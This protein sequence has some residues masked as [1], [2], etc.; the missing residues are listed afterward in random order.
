MKR[1]ILSVFTLFSLLGATAQVEVEMGAGYANQVFYSLENGVVASSPVNNWDLAF[2]TSGQGSVIRTNEGYGAELSLYNGPLADFTTLDTS[3]FEGWQTLHNSDASWSAGAF[4]EYL[5]DDFDLGWGMYSMVTHTVSGDSIYVLKTIDGAYKKLFIEKL[6]GGTYYMVHSNLDNTGLDTAKIAKA[7]YTSKNFIYYSFANDDIVDRE[8]ANDTWDLT[9]TKYSTELSPGT[10]Y[11]VTGVLTNN[12]ILSQEVSGLPAEKLAHNDEDF[13]ANNGIIGYD[14]KTFNMS[15]FS[16][17]IEDS[18]A[19]FVKTA[20]E[21]IY[22][23]VFT[24]FEGSST[25]VFEFTQ[26]EIITTGLTASNTTLEAYPNP[27]NGLVNIGATE[28]EVRVFAS[29]GTLQLS[30][31]LYDGL[32]DLSDL[33]AGI[34]FVQLTS[35]TSVYTTTITKQ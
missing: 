34:Y 19:Y 30:T 27:T 14:W 15:S 1:H 12:G 21:T 13:D 7:D 26:E 20:D 6:S 24:G 35:S 23:L 8:P 9:F 25:G 32:L 3:G 17:D 10:H 11:S 33:D 4:N 18:L 22:K 16:Y 29:N 2:E 5:K 28:G 31:P